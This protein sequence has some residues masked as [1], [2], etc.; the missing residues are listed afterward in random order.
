MLNLETFKSLPNKEIFASGKA[1]DEPGGLYMANTGAV[2]TWVAVKGGIDDWA[3][4]TH[5]WQDLEE[6]ARSGD[7][8]TF[9]GNIRSLVPCTDEVFALYRY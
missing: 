3:I 2:L 7:K 5:L 4:Y 1:V 8:V 6:V 9:E